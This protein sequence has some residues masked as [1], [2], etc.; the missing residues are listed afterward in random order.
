MWISHSRGLHWANLVGRHTIRL[1][2]FFLIVFGDVRRVFFLGGKQSLHDSQVPRGLHLDG[3]ANTHW[4][5]YNDWLARGVGQLPVKR[6]LIVCVAQPAL[7]L[8][9]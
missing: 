2:K 8:A 3:S 1:I 7:G 4:M 5:F 9:S 6:P